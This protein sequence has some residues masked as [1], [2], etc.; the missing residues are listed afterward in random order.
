MEILFV[1]ILICFLPLILINTKSFFALIILTMFFDNEAFHINFDTVPFDIQP[2]HLVLLISF[3][4][5]I[6]L[7]VD[8]IYKNYKI[9][10]HQ[11]F[12]IAFYFFALIKTIFNYNPDSFAYLGLFSIGVVLYFSFHFFLKRSDVSFLYKLLLLSGFFQLFIGF[13]QVILGLLTYFN[14]Y[15]F[16]FYVQHLDYVIFGRPFGTLIE[17]DYFGAISSFFAFLFLKEYISTKSNIYYYSFLLS[18]LLLFYGGVRAAIIGFI[19][20]FIYLVYYFRKEIKISLNDSFIIFYSVLFLSPL[21]FSTFVRFSYLFQSE[22]WIEGTNNPRILQLGVSFAQFLESPIFGNGLNAFNF[23]GDFYEDAINIEMPDWVNSG[24]DPSIIT[25]LLNDTGIFG[26]SIFLF[27]IYYYFKNLYLRINSE[28]IFVFCA[29]ASFL[30]TF[31]FTNGLILHFTWIFLAFSEILLSYD[32]S[33]H[34][35]F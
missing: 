29:I 32:L 5:L 26:F 33:S 35:K 15:N 1:F 31:L 30:T 27:F 21:L 23:L 9:E 20:S 7:L 17:P 16:D 3:P 19:P 10:I 11:Y 18:L 13:M 14:F 25:S 28:N 22:F 34:D 24:Y 8:K 12:L 2:V 6:I 4:L